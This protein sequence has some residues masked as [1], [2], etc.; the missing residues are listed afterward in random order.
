MQTH[1]TTR[2]QLFFLIISQ[3]SLN[4][5]KRNY[6]L[7]SSGGV[8]LVVLTYVYTPF[9][10]SFAI[11]K[12]IYRICKRKIPCD[13]RRS[14]DPKKILNQ[15]K[16]RELFGSV[17]FPRNTWVAEADLFSLLFKLSAHYFVKRRF[18]SIGYA[19]RLALICA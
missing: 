12:R 16:K 13:P 18:D 15:N 8:L 4:V 9:S 3:P 14:R 1:Y 17:I 19:L 7:L 10:R 2:W 5:N 11:K 6:N